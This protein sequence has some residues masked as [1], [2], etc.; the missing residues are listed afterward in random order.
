[1]LF[2]T[3]PLVILSTKITKLIAKNKN[4]DITSREEIAA[5]ANIGTNEGIFSQENKL[6]KTYL[7]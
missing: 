3:Y 5:L 2:I 6:F 4:T 1:M 7:N